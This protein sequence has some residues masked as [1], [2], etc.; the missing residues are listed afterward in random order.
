MF[1]STPFVKG[2]SK[3]YHF[4]N[5]E[6][7]ELGYGAGG[8]NDE[9]KINQIEEKN[10]TQ[11]TSIS[12]LENRATLIEERLQENETKVSENTTEISNIKS[13]NESQDTDISNAQQTAN[14]A[15]AIAKGR[16]K[17]TVFE[18]YSSMIEYLKSATNSEFNIGDNLLIKELNVPDYWVSAILETNDG[19]YGYYEVSLLETQKVDLTNY[20]DITK[21]DEL[22]NKKL[23][24]AIELT[25]SELKTLRDNSQLVVGATYIINDYTYV[26]PFS[27]PFVS[28]NHIFDIILIADSEN[29]LNENARARKHEGDT[30]F[31]NNDLSVWELKYTLENN[32]NGGSSDKGVIYWLK[33]EFDNECSYDFKNI[34]LPKSMLYKNDKLN[35]S[36]DYYY[37]FSIINSSDNT[38][39]DSSISKNNNVYQ[40]KICSTSITNVF[41]GNNYY[42]NTLVDCKNVVINY[43]YSND[44]FFSQVD[45][46][47]VGNSNYIRQCTLKDCLEIILNGLDYSNFTRVQYCNNTSMVHSFNVSK[48]GGTPEN[49]LNFSKIK[50][51][52]KTPTNVTVGSVLEQYENYGKIHAY[53]VD[54]ETLQIVGKY[55]ESNSDTEWKEITNN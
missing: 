9:E 11:D 33:D 47:F 2:S 8:S 4:A 46:L 35:S 43:S 21:T 17:A 13:K 18:T 23:D 31:A 48:V 34:L 38:V 36:I 16:T 50:V 15:L 49:Y 1:S 44:N 19:I 51:N 30:Y 54:N 10:A 45:S 5:N 28:G 40:N 55:L 41:I 27:V 25:Y 37:T 29:T 12:N 7:L 53:W 22:L 32:K 39:I 14:E 6:W 26:P 52:Y 42:R 20:Y 3:L 24:S